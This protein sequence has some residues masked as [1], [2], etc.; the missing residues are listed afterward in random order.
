MMKF[1]FDCIIV[2]GWNKKID[3]RKDAGHSGYDSKMMTD[4]KN[5]SQDHS[6]TWY[7]LRCKPN[8]EF[9]AWQQLEQKDVEVYLPAL[10]VKPVNHRSRTKKPYFPGYLFVRGEMAELYTKRIGLMRGVIGLVKFD[11]V[12]ASI[13]EEIVEVIRRQVMR[14]NQK[15][16]QAPNGFIP[17]EKLWIDDPLLQGIEAQFERCINGEE[18][19]CVLLTL[20]KGRTI[21]MEVPAAIVKRRVS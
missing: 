20:L 15:Q 10:S 8:F 14:E 16:S 12:P 7:V 6:S 13:P 5:P 11:G 18:R 17:G 3:C 1:L 21:R 9:I 19:I 2:P 4:D